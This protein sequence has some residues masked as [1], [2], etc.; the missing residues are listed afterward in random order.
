M[1][2]FSLRAKSL[3]SNGNTNLMVGQ[4]LKIRT[5]NQSKI[6]EC[7]GEEYVTSEKNYSSYI[8]MGDLKKKSTVEAAAERE[9]RGARK[10]GTVKRI[11]GGGNNKDKIISAKVYPETWARF[12]E[13]NR[14]Q[15]MT[16]NSVINMLISQYVRN[17]EGLLN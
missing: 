11:S 10:S 1:L 12:T 5:N 17:N 13:I 14:A 4:N 8:E 6:E 15:G 16:N 7:F 9:E 2:I 3:S